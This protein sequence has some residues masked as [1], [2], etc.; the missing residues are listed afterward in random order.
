M[1]NTKTSKDYKP[2]LEWFEGTW[3]RYKPEKGKDKRGRSGVKEEKLLE[4]SE[5]I[6]LIPESENIHKTIKRIF[7][8][9][10]QKIKTEK[11]YRLVYGRVFSI[12]FTFRRRFSC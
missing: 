12:W 5:K 3:T 11:K 1:N 6:N 4:I 8:S 7:D 9:R 2:K 10:Y